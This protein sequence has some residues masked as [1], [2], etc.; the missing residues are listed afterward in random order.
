MIA[1][2]SKLGVTAM[3][4]VVT[5]IGGTLVDSEAHMNL[6][7]G[8]A[9]IGTT[10]EPSEPALL[11]SGPL[12]AFG[13]G[14]FSKKSRSLISGA[15]L[16]RSGR[17]MSLI[18]KGKTKQVCGDK[19]KLAF[20]EFEGSGDC[21]KLKSEVCCSKEDD[22]RGGDEVDFGPHARESGS[23]SVSSLDVT[24]FVVSPED[25]GVELSAG[26]S[27]TARRSQ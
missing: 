21:K 23:G 26:R 12:A 16:S 14:S 17:V 11:S 15:K 22:F 5:N 27:S 6:Q 1:V 8:L 3:V 18:T 19:R 10:L 2:V 24:S 9:H 13:P 25:V 4:E 7:M 20:R